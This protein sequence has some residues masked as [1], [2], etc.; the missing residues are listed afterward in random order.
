MSDKI[1]LDDL[2]F[3]VGVPSGVPGLEHA[4]VHHPLLRTPLGTMFYMRTGNAT[5]EILWIYTLPRYR[6]QGVM[7]TLF[8]F[9]RENHDEIKRFLTA[10]GSDEGGQG[11]L[12]ALGFKRD[13]ITNDWTLEP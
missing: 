2:T 5:L 11:W 6:R 3:V 1:N 12:K 4:L 7:R 13:A 9:V 8:N 10:N